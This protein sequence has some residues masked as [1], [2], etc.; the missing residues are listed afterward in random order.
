MLSEEC[1]AAWRIKCHCLQVKPDNFLVARMPSALGLEFKT[2]GLDI[3]RGV[4]LELERQVFISD[5]HIP[6]Y[7]SHEGEVR[8]GSG[9]RTVA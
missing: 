1:F 6:P 8:Q 2:L 7:R 4:D 3:G 9:G 5:C